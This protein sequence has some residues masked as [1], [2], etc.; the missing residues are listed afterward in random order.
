MSLVHADGQAH[1][2]VMNTNNHPN[3]HHSDC[4]SRLLREAMGPGYQSATFRD[5]RFL[6]DSER[7]DKHT[8]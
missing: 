1:A 2:D 7:C 6:S 8:W 4:R 3:P 5:Q